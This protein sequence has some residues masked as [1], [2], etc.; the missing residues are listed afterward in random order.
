VYSV[1]DFIAMHPGGQQA[2]LGYAGRDATDA[3]LTKPHSADAH[4]RL[5]AY[6]VGTVITT[7]I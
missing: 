6:K 4:M 1:G 7:I 3:F 2:I 5:A